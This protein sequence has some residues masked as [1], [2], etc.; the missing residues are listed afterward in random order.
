MVQWLYG[1]TSTNKCNEH[2]LLLKNKPMTTKYSNNFGTQ[3]II[4]VLQFIVIYLLHN[5]E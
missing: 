1:T 5:N 4:S 2:V 3:N